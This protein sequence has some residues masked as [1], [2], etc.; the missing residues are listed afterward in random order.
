M[1]LTEK[2]FKKLDNRLLAIDRA[3]DKVLS[4]K[5][6]NMKKL[7]IA[8][9]LMGIF[10]VGHVRA[11]GF[12]GSI[13]LGNDFDYYWSNNKAATYGP[14]LVQGAVNSPRGSPI[15]LNAKIGYEKD[16]NSSFGVDS[17]LGYNFSDESILDANLIYHVSSGVALKVGP[18]LS[19]PSFNSNI[20]YQTA[21]DV[22]LTKNQFLELQYQE[23]QFN[24]PSTT[25]GDLAAKE[26]GS[27][28]NV[29]V[30][31]SNV[32]ISYGIRF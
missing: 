12:K 22:D 7:L 20:G 32:G 9:M 1:Y 21:V 15:E 30:Q 16:L 13:G 17:N 25:S 18:N 10:H 6:L 23:S 8:I 3:L 19:N 27:P 14:R 31:R 28:I 24:T 4:E 26:P 29:G 5:P 11:D 2:S